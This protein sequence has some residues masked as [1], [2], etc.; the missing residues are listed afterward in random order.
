MSRRRLC[1]MVDELTRRVLTARSPGPVLR[2]GI[3][4]PCGAGKTTLAGRL[5]ARL[6]KHRRAV[7]RA[8]GDDFQNRREIR[9]QLG[10][11]S[12]EGF[13]RHTMDFG[14]LRRE[15]LEPLGPGGDLRYRTSVA[16]PVATASRGDILVLDGLFLC[17]PEL[18]ACFD[19][20]VLVDPLQDVGPRRSK[21]LRA[22]SR[23]AVKS[24]L[25]SMARLQRLLAWSSFA[26][27][28]IA[29][30]VADSSCGTA[31]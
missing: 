16:S 17:S 30:T 20:T 14:A 23:R 13:F 27:A 4:G 3:D 31:R 19:L 28:P 10:S 11:R 29:A 5:Q 8:C 12:A 15:L 24:A 7:I 2:V 25:T 26:S 18:E 22:R 9:W 1:T 6:Q 21:P